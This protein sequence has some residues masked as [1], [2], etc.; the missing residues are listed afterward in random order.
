MSIHDHA[1]LVTV[2]SIHDDGDLALYMSAK[3]RIHLDLGDKIVTTYD[4]DLVPLA[5]AIL[6]AVEPEALVENQKVADP[7]INL[8]ALRTFADDHRELADNADALILALEGT[9]G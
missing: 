4:T 5:K 6:N 8:A 2:R 7:A 3:G 9:R 1:P